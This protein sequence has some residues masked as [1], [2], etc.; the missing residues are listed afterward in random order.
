MFVM[1]CLL[2]SFA[3]IDIAFFVNN[4]A[5]TNDDLQNTN[6]KVDGLNDFDN[7]KTEPDNYLYE[8]L[9]KK[10]ET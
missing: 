8:A 1:I 2:L 9:N 3:M 10:I 4:M 6:A 5:Y 7:T